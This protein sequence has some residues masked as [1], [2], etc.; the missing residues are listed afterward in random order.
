MRPNLPHC[1]VTPIPSICLG[2]HYYLA[3][4]LMDSIIGMYHHF[5]GS[6]VL[7]NTDHGIAS[8]ALLV[9]M[10]A[11][12]YQY[13]KCSYNSVIGVFI[14]FSYLFLHCYINCLDRKYPHIPDTNTWDGS[15]ALFS[16]C[17]YFELYS[18][19]INWNY[20]DHQKDSQA[21]E[22]SIKNRSRARKIVY[23]YFRT[24]SLHGTGRSIT[25]YEAFQDVYAVFLA[26]QAHVLILLKK[27][28]YTS[29][30]QG[31]T[32]KSIDPATVCLS[33]CKCMRGGPG[34]DAFKRMTILSSQ[35]SFYWPGTTYDVVVSS[36][37]FYSSYSL[38]RH[39][40]LY[41]DNFQIMSRSMA[42]FMETG[43]CHPSWGFLLPIS[44]L[45]LTLSSMIMTQVCIMGSFT[46][47]VV[48][49]MIAMMMSQA[50]RM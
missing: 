3:S 1:V 49:R 25:G 46:P 50:T 34:W 13:F 9:R 38:L 42:W 33:V 14:L 47:L 36:C 6:D 28:A 23:W 35:R 22:A 12:Y 24:H 48:N 4:T 18:A 37:Q 15:L 27:A 2:G 32:M 17:N 5:V 11:Y 21:F 19:L 8:H 45:D 10:L 44:R 39:S 40:K 41:D 26:H 16:L 30:F 31:D 20:A 43:K 7:T 29:G